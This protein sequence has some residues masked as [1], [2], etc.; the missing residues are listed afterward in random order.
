[1]DVGQET[2]L[3]SYEINLW[4]FSKRVVKGLPNISF[5]NDTTYEFCQ[6]GKQT[7]I[8]FHS[9]N[10]V[11]TTRPLKLLHFDLFGPTRIASLD[12]IKYGLIIVDDFFEFTWVIFLVYKDEACVAFKVFSK[13]GQ[14]EKG[15][16]IPSIISD[17]VVV[18]NVVD[19]V[20]KIL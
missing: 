18:F 7:K 13:G 1:M 12:G 17:H 11:S 14:N 20:G 9:K 5:D 4:D 3:C 10:V 15:F 19:L 6:R 8:Y 16:Y 2:W